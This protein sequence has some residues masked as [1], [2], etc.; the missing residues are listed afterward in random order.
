MAVALAEVPHAR[1]VNAID[2]DYLHHASALAS[3]GL[4]VVELCASLLKG[5][6]SAALASPG[7]AQPAS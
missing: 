4:V 6:V 7:P 5:S 2:S 3:R 1:L